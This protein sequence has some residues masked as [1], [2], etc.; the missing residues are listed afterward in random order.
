MILRQNKGIIFAVSSRPENMSLNCGDTVDS[1]NNRKRFLDKIGMNYRS[2]V[3]TKQVHGANVVCVEEKDKGKGALSL[4][5][6]LPDTD[7]LITN[8]TN[9]PLAV[10]TADCLPVLLYDLAAQVIG[11]VHAGWKSSKENIAP[12]T[13][14]L[15]REKFNIHPQN[16][17]VFFGPALRSCCNEVS[18]EFI[19][20]LRPG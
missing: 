6:A 3:C 20:I 16:L 13:V 1:L 14:S 10:F 9:I 8:I 4:D 17:F 5:T 18:E 15:M 19:V 2:L 11:V 12:E 7:A